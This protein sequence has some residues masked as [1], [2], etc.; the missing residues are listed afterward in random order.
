MGSKKQAIILVLSSICLVVL[1][2]TYFPFAALIAFFPLIS[3]LEKTAEGEQP[4]VYWFT[5]AL[6]VLGLNAIFTVDRLALI[7]GYSVGLTLA[8][9]AYLIT[10]HLSK[11]RLG[12][13]TILLFWLSFDYLVLK[14]LPEASG[15][16]LSTFFDGYDVVSWSRNTGNLGITAWIITANI[17]LY[18]VFLWR[19]AVFRNEI[20]WLSLIY[21][22]LIIC[23]PVVIGLYIV[24]GWI[25]VT[26]AEV[27][28]VYVENSNTADI[29][30]ME[31]G[32]WLGRTATWVSVMIL[33]YAVIKGKVK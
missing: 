9:S 22:L 4:F 31:N 23:T 7:L 33:V 3:L 16:F 14:V 32:E 8:I 29:T 1:A 17:L 10:S 18:Y 15:A 25:P 28:A 13:F 5:P 2:R 24:P 6:I 21:S 27:K 20:R 12:V 26:I 11:N 19:D 30:Y